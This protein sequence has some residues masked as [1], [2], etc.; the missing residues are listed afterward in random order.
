MSLSG[1]IGGCFCEEASE[2]LDKRPPTVSTGKPFSHLRALRLL[3]NN[4]LYPGINT[5]QTFIGAELFL[6]PN[7]RSQRYVIA[8]VSFEF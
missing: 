4:P 6:D 3:K 7:R 8:D 5:K 1:R 2:E